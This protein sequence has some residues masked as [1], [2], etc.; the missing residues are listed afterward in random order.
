M[1]F[2]IMGGMVGMTQQTQTG[3]GTGTVVEGGRVPSQEERMEFMIMGGMVGKTQQTIGSRARRTAGT[4]IIT[5]VTSVVVTI[6]TNTENLA[7]EA[8]RQETREICMVIGHHLLG[9]FH[10]LGSLHHQQPILKDWTFMA[11][12]P[13][14]SRLRASQRKAR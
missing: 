14:E 4:I 9:S 13:M 10:L 12:L 2:M 7:R 6:T 5:G 1:E 3:A 8:R 11:G